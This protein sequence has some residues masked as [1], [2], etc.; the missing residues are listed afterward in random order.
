MKKRFKLHAIVGSLLVIGFVSGC[1]V[2]SKLQGINV[3]VKNNLD[4][5][6]KEVVSIQRSNLSELLKKTSEKD[7]R[8]KIQDSKEYLRTQ[9]I[10]NDN[11]GKGD[12]LLF[13][14]DIKAKSVINYAIVSDT[15]K[16]PESKITTYSRFVPERIDDYAWENNKVAFRTYGPVAQQLVEEHKEGGTLSSGIDL[17]FKK[18]DY[19]IID[20]WYKKNVASPGYYHI[21]HGEGYDPYHVGASRG[22]GGTGI[23]ENDSLQVAKNYTSY[24]TIATG[25]LRTVFELTYAP[26]SSYGVHET[27]RISLDLNSNFS[28]F[29]ISFRSDKKI[30]NYTLGITLHE[31][32]GEVNINKVK[33]W[34]RHWEA[35]DDSFVGEGIVLNPGIIDTAFAN[36]SNKSDQSNLLI[37]TNPENKLTYYAGFAWTGSRQVSDVTDWDEMLN[38]QAEIIAN[39]LQIIIK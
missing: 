32:K 27:K 13:E 7:I 38:K 36:D 8:V 3:E 39:P 31:K 16:V 34:F 5:N 21:E 1:S 35:I 28:K 24:K 20:S 18:V 19:S 37:L 17:W 25:P 29:E 4:F 11:D 2:K 26:W 15:V 30:P 33:G 10:D 12:E 22:T 9:W 14:V 6:R 23:W